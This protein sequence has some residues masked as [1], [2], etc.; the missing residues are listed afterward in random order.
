M[1]RWTYNECVRA[2]KEKVCGLSRTDLRS[3]LLNRGSPEVE[4][5]PWLWDVPYD[6]RDGAMVDVLDAHASCQA[7]RAKEPD[8]AKREKYEVHFRSRKKCKTES[9]LIR[10]KHYKNGMFYAK[11][12]G[13]YKCDPCF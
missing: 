5:R 9:I 6:V 1:A 12:F 13:E 11:Y 4:Y 8:P 7:K 2:T 3:H 10:S